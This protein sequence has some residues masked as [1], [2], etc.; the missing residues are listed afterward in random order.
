M[1]HATPGMQYLRG[2]GYTTPTQSRRRAE[3]P[4]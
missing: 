4:L 3:E 2:V 1:F